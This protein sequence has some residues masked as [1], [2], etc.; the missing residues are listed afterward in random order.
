PRDTPIRAIALTNG[1]LDHTLGLFSLRESQ[2]LV[3]Y[4]TERVWAGLSEKNAI[5]RTLR[6]FENQV[7]FRKLAL[8]R[9]TEIEELGISLTAIA[10]PGKLPVHLLDARSAGALVGEADHPEDNIALRIERNGKAAIYAT[11]VKNAGA[12]RDKLTPC[13]VLFLDGTFWSSDELTAGG[14]GKARAEDMA[15]HPLSG[16]TGSLATLANLEGV[17]RKILTHVN[18]TNPILRSDSDARNA[19]KMAGWEIATDGMEI[20]A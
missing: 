15:H 17:K 5:F 16:A 8:D 1:D 6:R 3:V 7:T 10:A 12:I 4:A 14:L 13:D 18:N 2:P 19:V 20:S 11:A 9:K